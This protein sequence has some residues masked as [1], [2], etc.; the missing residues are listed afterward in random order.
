M[1]TSSLEVASLKVCL[2]V[3]GNRIR[4]C[5][6]QTCPKPIRCEAWRCVSDM[7]HGSANGTQFDAC[8]LLTSYPFGGF[9]LASRDFTAALDSS[10]CSK[11]STKAFKSFSHSAGSG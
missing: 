11:H 7:E 6:P 1:N 8:A 4:S 5:L 10:H 9:N 2:S 3:G